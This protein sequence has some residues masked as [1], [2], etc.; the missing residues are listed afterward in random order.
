MIAFCKRWSRTVLEVVS[1]DNRTAAR[2]NKTDMVPKHALLQYLRSFDQA[3]KGTELDLTKG[4]YS[5]IP[6]EALNLHHLKSLIMRS[7]AL[8]S[9]PDTISALTSLVTLDVGQNR[10]SKI[11]PMIGCLTTLVA[12]VLKS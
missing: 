10:I 8:T 9:I 3:R 6:E 11:N 12:G 7:N 4:G 2:N 5:T 1:G